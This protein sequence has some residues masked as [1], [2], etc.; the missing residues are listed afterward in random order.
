[1]KLWHYVS[2]PH[3]VFKLSHLQNCNLSHPNHLVHF[4]TIYPPDVIHHRTVLTQPHRAN[5]TAKRGRG[6]GRG[7]GTSSRGET[8]GRGS[9]GG[10]GGGGGSGG[11]GGGGGSNKSNDGAS[12]TANGNEKST[13]GTSGSTGR[14]GQT[15]NGGTRKPRVKKA[16][17][18]EKA[19]RELAEKKR[20]EAE[21]LK[22][23]GRIADGAKEAER[24]LAL[25]GGAVT[26]E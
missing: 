11:G 3:H 5:G 24:M 21:A 15:A 6:R 9:R 14:G 26:V 17:R 7:T 18:L 8:S 22:V 10:R 25:A 16:E 2:I 23:A 19:E 13:T 12:T 1:M 4:F 20:A